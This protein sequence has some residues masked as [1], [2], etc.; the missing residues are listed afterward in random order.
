MSFPYLFLH[1]YPVCLLMT[2]DHEWA[3]EEVNRPHHLQV[4]AFLSRI[5]L[6]TGLNQWCPSDTFQSNVMFQRISLRKLRNMCSFFSG[7][8]QKITTHTSMTIKCPL[9]VLAVTGS[10]TTQPSRCHPLFPILAPAHLKF[11]INPYENS[12]T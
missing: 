5:M 10:A 7:G 4:S 12:T 8:N 2:S 9:P 11:F 1:Y 3:H 6:M